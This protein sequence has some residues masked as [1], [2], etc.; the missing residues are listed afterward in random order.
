MTKEQINMLAAIR[1]S[2]RECHQLIDS[3]FDR[4]ISHLL[5]E[6]GPELR[7]NERVL[8]LAALPEVFK[9]RQPVSLILPSGTEVKTPTWEKAVTAILHDCGSNPRHHKRMLEL[10][11]Q[12]F[13]N[14]R[15]LLSAAPE[16]MDAP[17][18][19]DEELYW[20]SSFDTEVVLGNLSGKLLPKVG[21]D[22]QGVVVRYRDPQLGS[23]AT[24]K[25]QESKAQVEQ[26]L[27]L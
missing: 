10:R 25:V 4:L 12:T 11:G 22:Y 9:G 2:R 13:G 19:I 23:T 27:S 20:E 16:G 6:S 15:P 14:F 3:Q 26:T 7:G 5:E 8:T 21:Y 17:L 24:E 1:S 18:K